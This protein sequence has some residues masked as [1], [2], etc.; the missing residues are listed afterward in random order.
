VG[1]RT[2]VAEAPADDLSGYGE[3][4]AVLS[5]A[6][7]DAVRLQTRTGDLEGTYAALVAAV[8]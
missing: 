1:R 3:R 2:S 6:R 5:E 7:S 4:L 8:G